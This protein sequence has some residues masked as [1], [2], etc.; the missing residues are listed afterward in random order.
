LPLEVRQ[1]GI[2]LDVGDQASA[3]DGADN[4]GQG[5]PRPGLD[6]SERAEIIGE[7]VEA[8]LRALRLQGER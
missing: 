3:A 1:I 7:C 8:V 4:F 6:P 2:R 5:E